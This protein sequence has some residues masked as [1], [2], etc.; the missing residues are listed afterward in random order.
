MSATVKRQ[1][2]RCSRPLRRVKHSEREFW[3]CEGWFDTKDPCYA[4]YDELSSNK[5]HALAELFGSI[6]DDKMLH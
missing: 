2:P 1:C 5:E 6:S 3:R 4:S